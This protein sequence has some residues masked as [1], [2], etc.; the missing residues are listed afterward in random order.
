MPAYQSPDVRNLVVGKANVY[1]KR[2]GDTERRHIGNVTA[3]G[4]EP[5]I[6]TLEHFSSMAGVRTRDRVVT[7]T[8][9]ATLTMTLEEW[10][11]ENLAI[12]FLGEVDTDSDGNTVVLGLTQDL[13]RGEL[14]A[15]MSNDVGPRYNFE[16][17]SVALRPAGSVGIISEEWAEIEIE[18]D[19]EAVTPA[20]QTPRFWTATLVGGSS[21]TES[22]APTATDTETNT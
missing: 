19:V 16:F 11:P 2:E 12:A 21:G 1:F 3:F 20:G 7:L 13:I 10:T 15:E 17:G 14:S 22:T 6:E 18:G 8:R 5:T 4:A 9:S